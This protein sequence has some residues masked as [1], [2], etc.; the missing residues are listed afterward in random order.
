MVLTVKQAA[1]K[2]N[3]SEQRIRHLAKTGRFPNATR[4]GNAWM[5]PVADLDA[6]QKKQPGRPKGSSGGSND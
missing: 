6:L 2:L 1:E 5:I 3:M 4:F